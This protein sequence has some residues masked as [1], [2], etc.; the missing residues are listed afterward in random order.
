MYLGAARGQAGEAQSGLAAASRIQNTKDL[1][2]AK[3]K[4][5][6]R[7]ARANAIGQLGTTFALQGMK[8]KGTK[9]E[10]FLNPRR[11]GGQV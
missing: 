1:Q 2:A 7:M 6:V 9:V 3:A 11:I 10:A 8:N 5:Q 4:Q